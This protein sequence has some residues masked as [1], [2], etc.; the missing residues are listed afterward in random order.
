ML[1]VAYPPPPWY[2]V[3]ICCAVSWKKGKYA[4]ILLMRCGSSM[5][6]VYT[7]SLALQYFRLMVFSSSMVV[8]F[9]HWL[10]HSWRIL[11][12]MWS[13]PLC[14]VVRLSTA[15]PM[16][17]VIFFLSLLGFLVISN[18]EDY[19]VF[20]FFWSFSPIA[21]CNWFLFLFLDCSPIDIFA[22]RQEQVS[23]TK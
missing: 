16:A 22:S 21:V 3:Q 23:T 9:L 5:L 15:C 6:V 17:L 1:C 14:S 8:F 19:S 2:L 12:C 20:V 7:V 18:P 13:F 11:C 10:C 4:M